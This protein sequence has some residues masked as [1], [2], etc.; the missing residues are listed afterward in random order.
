MKNLSWAFRLIVIVAGLTLC[1]LAVYLAWPTIDFLKLKYLPKTERLFQETRLGGHVIAFV[2]GLALVFLA[3]PRR[4]K[5]PLPSPPPKAV[6]YRIF[7]GIVCF[8]IFITSCL[9]YIRE[10]GAKPSKL[11]DDVSVKVTAVLFWLLVAVIC[12]KWKSTPAKSS[13]ADTPG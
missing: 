6:K 11:E 13:E 9:T 12:F 10:L 8:L 2:L 1:G 5:E 3:I 4:R 7:A